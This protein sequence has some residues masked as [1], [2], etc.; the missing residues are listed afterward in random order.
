MLPGAVPEASPASYTP[1]F[2][3]RWKQFDI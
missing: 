3:G 2:K 1:H